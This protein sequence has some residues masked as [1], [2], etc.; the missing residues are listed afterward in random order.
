[1]FGQL[2]LDWDAKACGPWVCR[3]PLIDVIWNDLYW[4]GGNPPL[5]LLTIL[6]LIWGWWKRHDL[7]GRFLSFFGC[8]SWKCWMFVECWWRTMLSVFFGVF[9]P[10][11]QSHVWDWWWHKF[12]MLWVTINT[13]AL[14]VNY[15]LYSSNLQQFWAQ[16]FSPVA[17]NTFW[18]HPRK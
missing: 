7:V 6:K 9:W 15:C 3:H 13:A 17:E 16:T 14:R 8:S 10:S 1:M 12:Q 11:H 18:T 4:V 2:R 5:K